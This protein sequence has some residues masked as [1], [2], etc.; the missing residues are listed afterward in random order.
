ME[1]DLHL[2]GIP[3]YD[4]KHF[5]H[6]SSNS[7]LYPEATIAEASAENRRLTSIIDERDRHIRLLS[8]RIAAERSKIDDLTSQYNQATEEIGLV[9]SEIQKI[10]AS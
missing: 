6:L 2:K 5:W 9:E 7:L 4:G 1:N 8:E 10:R 3:L